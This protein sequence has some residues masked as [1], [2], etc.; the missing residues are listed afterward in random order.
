MWVARGPA[1]WR[2]Q[3]RAGARGS[4]GADDGNAVVEFIGGAVVL[5]VPLMYLVLVLGRVQAA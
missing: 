4:A 3:A 5:L 2:S 1:R